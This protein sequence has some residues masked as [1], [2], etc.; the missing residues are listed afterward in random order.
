M[1]NMFVCVRCVWLWYRFVW[2]NPW[3]IAKAKSEVAQLKESRFGRPRPRHGLKLMHWISVQLK[4]R[5]NRMFW[6]PNSEDYG[7]HIFYNR[8]ERDGYI[9][10]PIIN[11]LTY[12][13]VGNLNGISGKPLPHYISV[14]FTGQSDESNMDRVI[15]GVD[16]DSYVRAVYASEHYNRY[17]TTELSWEFLMYISHMSLQEFLSEAGY[18]ESEIGQVRQY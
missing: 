16:E 14:D 3:S 6:D 5:K 7:I 11:K 4:Q 1:Y 9:L 8:P 17:A 13:T 15:I 18:Y 10:L 2:L 12:Y